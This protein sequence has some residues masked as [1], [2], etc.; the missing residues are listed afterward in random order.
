MIGIGIPTSHSNI[1][2]IAILLDRFVENQQKTSG[3][4]PKHIIP[5]GKGFLRIG[6]VERFVE[7]WL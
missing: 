2:R 3:F 1:G 7:S 5:S 4:V 6:P